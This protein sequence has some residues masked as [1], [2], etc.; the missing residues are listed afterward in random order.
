[1]GNAQ[2]LFLSQRKGGI[3]ARDR[4]WLTGLNVGGLNTMEDLLSFPDA[5]NLIGFLPT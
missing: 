3:E 5:E 2:P 1:M 4:T